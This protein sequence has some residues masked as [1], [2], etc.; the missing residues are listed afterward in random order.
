MGSGKLIS[1]GKICNYVEKIILKNNL[2]FRKD[3]I[4][5]SKYKISK[6]KPANLKNYKIKINNLNIYDAL[7]KTIRN[8]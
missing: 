7:K 8:I 6:N 2:Y 5:L 1:V 3:K 4:R